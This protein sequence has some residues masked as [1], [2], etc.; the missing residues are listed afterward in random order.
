MLAELN[1]VAVLAIGFV[2][3]YAGGE[4]LIRGAV[5]LSRHLGVSRLLIG[6]VIVAFG[7]SAPELFVAVDAVLR[8]TPDIAIGNVVGSN[9]ANV[10][11]VL[12]LAAL[13]WPLG[14]RR[15]V[16]RDGAVMLAATGLFIWF[17]S[18]GEIPRDGGL[19]LVGLLI[20]YI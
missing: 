11:L 5:G 18:Q 17:A 1:P 8:D 7:T 3:L 12:A 19:V 2:F 10:L 20:L 9:I 13:F 16:L 6:I 14:E 15:V 4:F